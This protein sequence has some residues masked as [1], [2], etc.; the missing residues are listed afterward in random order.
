V[1]CNTILKLYVPLNTVKSSGRCKLTVVIGLL[2]PYNYIVVTVVTMNTVRTD[3]AIMS[4]ASHL[5][6]ITHRP[7]GH[8]AGQPPVITIHTNIPTSFTKNINLF[9]VCKSVHHHTFN[10]INQQ[11]AATSQ[12]YYLSFKYSLTCFGHPHAHHQDLQ[13]LQ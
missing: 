9:R 5:K 3:T 6:C 8:L 2:S 13:F 4:S 7:P 12:V 11:V 1:L 10:W